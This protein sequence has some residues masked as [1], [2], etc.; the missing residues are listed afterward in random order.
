MSNRLL[1]TLLVLLM[2]GGIALGVSV[3][4]LGP[5]RVE[6][7]MVEIFEDQQDVLAEQAALRIR[8]SL[9]EVGARLLAAEQRLS[10]TA[11]ERRP[12]AAAEMLARLRHHSDARRGITLAILDRQGEVLA[13]EPG[14]ATENI[15]ELQAHVR[16]I[17]PG[18]LDEKLK[19]SRRNL[20][21][22]GS[23]WLAIPLD[24][25]Y[26]LAANIA[27]DELARRI[28]EQVLVTRNTHA[29][30]F[31]ARGEVISI[32]GSGPNLPRS[33]WVMGSAR[34]PDTE[35]RVKI[36]APRAAIAPE[37]RDRARDLV[38]GS[39]GVMS[40]FLA[41]MGIFIVLLRREQRE[42]VA[43]I[44][45]LA[46]QD[47]LATLGMMAASTAHEIR[48][49]ITVASLQLQVVAA[50]VD[51]DETAQSVQKATA[52]VGR[53]ADLAENLSR[54][55]GKERSASVE[56]TLAS[57]VE[58]ALG[59]VQPKLRAGVELK[60]DVADD[61]LIFGSRV[62]IAQVIV[63]LVLNA[64]DA[65]G[66]GAA[67]GWIEIRARRDRDDAVLRVSD[68]GPGIEPAALNKIFEPFFSTKDGDAGSGGTGIGL[69]LCSQI[70]AQ[71]RGSIHA[72]NA[73]NAGARFIARLPIASAPTS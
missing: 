52:S 27:M 49:A 57:A 37:I 25:Q 45:L 7:R 10:R 22:E 31:G 26:I 67:D 64:L 30:L 58:D 17:E 1:S 24:E 38:Y 40:L 13:V 62:S 21:G 60:V 4:L 42:R 71:H 46:H 3:L 20:S 14:E 69:W 2:L 48:N 55:A 15:V 11:D 32:G 23:L 39:F 70:I 41:S 8:D 47:K 5:D 28:F 43:Q 6:A 35:L 59:V 12:D 50:G 19:I 16:R 34:V 68:S 51:D 63:N 9:H 66:D 56:F 53:L 54:Y 73:E 36:A 18:W 33:E 29:A 72:E 61:L 65:I 44:R